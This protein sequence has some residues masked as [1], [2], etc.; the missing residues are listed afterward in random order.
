[1]DSHDLAVFTVIPQSFAS[2]DKLS[3]WPIR[4][5]HKPIKRSTLSHIIKQA[6]LTLQDFLNL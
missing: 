1:M 6:K 4:P 3:S 2:N 5:A